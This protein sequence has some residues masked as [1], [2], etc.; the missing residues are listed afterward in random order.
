MSIKLELYTDDALKIKACHAYWQRTPT[1]TDW[2]NP[3]TLVATMLES[4]VD[5]VA[6]ILAKLCA[7]VSSTVT[8]VLAPSW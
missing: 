5:E 1:N 2:V 7:A 6:D 3:T 4:T 8:W